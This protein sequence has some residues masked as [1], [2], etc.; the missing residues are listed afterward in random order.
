ME[1]TCQEDSDLGG[2]GRAAASEQ[3]GGLRFRRKF[4]SSV[5]VKSIL[6]VRTCFVRRGCG[7]RL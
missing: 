7:G 2:P 3:I 6:T 1:S 4:W 5:I